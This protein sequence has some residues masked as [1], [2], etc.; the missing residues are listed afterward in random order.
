MPAFPRPH[1]PGPRSVLPA[2]AVALLLGCAALLPAAAP[3]PATPPQLKAEQAR[4]SPA[5][6]GHAKSRP[7]RILRYVAMGDSYAAAPLAP[8]G[9]PR[10]P[11]CV[12]SRSGYPEVAARALGARL[13]NVSCS[14]ARIRDFGERQTG[15]LRPQ[16][17]ALERGTDVVSLTIGGNDTHLVRAALR[18]V[19][20]LPEPVG[21]SCADRYT[22]GGRDRIAADIAAWAPAL[23]AA[24]DEIHRRAPHAR[25]FV[26]GYGEYF[27]RGGCHP[28]QPLWA[29]DADYLQGSIDRLSAVLRA[30]AARHRAVFVDTRPLTRG[31]DSCAPARERYLEGF[32]PTH[33]ALGLHPNAEGSAAI[34]RRLASVI[35]RF[36]SGTPSTRR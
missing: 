14:A 8:H 17:T 33:R 2:P 30:E 28:V 21:R 7:A 11:M 23:G 3:A 36:R 6:T 20:P 22:A 9:D 34:G 24:L 16:S 27:R 5:H 29:R 35:A 15:L 13:V 25:I 26:V 31:H 4:T 19:N 10:A 1:R 32:L 12:R 18:C